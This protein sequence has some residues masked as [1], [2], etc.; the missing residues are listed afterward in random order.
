MADTEIHTVGLGEVRRVAPRNRAA[1]AMKLLKEYVRRHSGVSTV[2]VSTSV[3]E[4]LWSDGAANPPN[5][6]DVQVL[7]DADTAHVELAD[8][9][10]DLGED[11]ES[12]AEEEPVDLSDEELAERNVDE[13]K[14]LVET[15]VV[16]PQ[17]A[18]DVEY[19]GKNRK[20]LIEWLQDR[21]DRDEDAEEPDEES[22]EPGSAGEEEETAGEA[23]T[24]ETYDLP[25][26]VVETFE[27]GTIDEG[28]D[29]AKE[30]G[31]QE[32]EKLL[33]FEEA[34]QNRKGMK[35]WLRS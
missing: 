2:S 35:K 6:I 34:H 33:N 1:K 25:D 14:D 20:T 17:R 11:E 13:V 23:A 3:N 21:L 31:K 22:L 29:A 19:A 18:L 32:L 28:K 26:D 15:G 27:D 4:A 10:F 8:M 30:L 7:V 16:D 9:E 5:S 12:G 24:E